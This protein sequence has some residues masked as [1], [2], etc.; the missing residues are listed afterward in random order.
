MADIPADI[1]KL[2]FEDALAELERIVRTLEEG[3]VKL[4]D[5]IAAYTRGALLKRHCDVKLT[6]AEAKI[7]KVVPG[8]DGG[9]SVEPTT[10]R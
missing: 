6:E 3:K 5:A 1:A 9:L 10:L 2:S 7:E 8:A 4:D